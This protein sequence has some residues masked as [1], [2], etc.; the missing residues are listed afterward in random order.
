MKQWLSSCQPFIP[1]CLKNRSLQTLNKTKDIRLYM[2]GN[3]KTQL[4][5]I[6]TSNKKSHKKKTKQ[7]NQE[8]NTIN[9]YLQYHIKYQAPKSRTQQ[10]RMKAGSNN[11]VTDYYTNQGRPPDTVKRT[12]TTLKE[13]KFTCH[14]D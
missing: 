10:P 8:D 9:N 1:Y 14:P 2:T 5:K 7:K 4:P 3:K 12:Q 11:R 6:Y 13:Y